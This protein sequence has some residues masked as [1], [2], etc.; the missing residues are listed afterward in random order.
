MNQYNNDN[1]Q[2]YTHQYNLHLPQPITSPL[3]Y[4]RSASTRNIRPI[5]YGPQGNNF[6]YDIECIDYNPYRRFGARK[7]DNGVIYINGKRY[8]NKPQKD[9]SL[10]H[11]NNQYG[12]CFRQEKQTQLSYNPLQIEQSNEVVIENN[13]YPSFRKIPLREQKAIEFDIKPT[14]Y[15]GNCISDRYCEPCYYLRNRLRDSGRGVV[16]QRKSCWDNYY[17]RNMR[18]DYKDN[19]VWYG[20]SDYYD[21]MSNYY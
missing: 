1:T 20:K 11:R 3:H 19:Y 17:S 15:K 12:G 6:T 14:V 5:V 4:Y 8:H 7:Y 2:H 21:R 16:G 13:P 9:N 10:R 18:S